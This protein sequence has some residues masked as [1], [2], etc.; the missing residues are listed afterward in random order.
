VHVPI[1]NATAGIISESGV[2]VW[3]DGKFLV[4]T[5]A[6]VGVRSG[7]ADRSFVWFDVSAGM[8]SFASSTVQ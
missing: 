6:A 7:G 3:R 1:T 8:F 5:A 2:V 4:P